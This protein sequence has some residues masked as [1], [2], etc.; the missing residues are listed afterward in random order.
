MAHQP[1]GA[2]AQ[3][4]LHR[5]LGVVRP[6]QLLLQRREDVFTEILMDPPVLLQP[7][8]AD[9][10]HIGLLVGEVLHRV[11][12]EVLDPLLAGPLV[13]LLL[14]FEVE[15]LIDDPEKPL[16]LLV[17]GVHTDAVLLPPL[18][19]GIHIK[20]PPFHSYDIASPEPNPP[21]RVFC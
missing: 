18:E 1:S 13:V 21:A 16:V 12:L 6:L 11:A 2:H 14:L 10:C 17:D 4:M 7:L 8:V 9:G 15:E 20:S 19:L 5:L 3:E